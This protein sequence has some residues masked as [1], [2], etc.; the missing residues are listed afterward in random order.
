MIDKDDKLPDDITLKNVI[1]NVVILIISAPFWQ[2]EITAKSKF[3]TF[4]RKWNFG[5]GT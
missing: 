1:K 2:M 5:S 4:L 3:L